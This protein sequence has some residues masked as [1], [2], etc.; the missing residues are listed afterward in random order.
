MP[1]ISGH[2]YLGVNAADGEIYMGFSVS[3]GVSRARYVMSSSGKYALQ[4]WNN[5]SARWEELIAWPPYE[6]SRYG[7]CGPFGYCDNTDDGAA[8]VPTCKCLDGFEPASGEEW[9]G[10]NFSR[11]CR[12]REALR[13]GDGDRFLG[14]PRMKAPDRFVHVRNRS[15]DECA[16]ECSGNCSCVAYAYA[17]LNTSTINGDSTRCLL[18][19]GELI[20]AEK[21]SVDEAGDE[22]LYLRLSGLDTGTDSCP[23]FPRL[24][25]N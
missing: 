10:G 17:N 8:A 13:C 14:L 19:V 25:T 4:S 6:C 15:Y 11:G 22:T 1:N 5:A 12:R 24:F 18:W 16:A 20:D 2:V 9:S 3:D 23:L 7:Y 21:I